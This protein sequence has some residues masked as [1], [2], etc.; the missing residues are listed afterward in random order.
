MVDMYCYIFIVFYW[1][2]VE[3]DVIRCFVI[4]KV[5]MISY[6]IIYNFVVKLGFKKVKFI[7]LIFIIV[8]YMY[9]FRS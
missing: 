1:K 8:N 6:V 4:S 2:D 3:S 5:K 9:V 7:R